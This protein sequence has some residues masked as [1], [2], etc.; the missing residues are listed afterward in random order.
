MAL[1]SRLKEEKWIRK[2]EKRR[3]RKKTIES[4]WVYE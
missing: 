4:K 2:E 1:L 3:S